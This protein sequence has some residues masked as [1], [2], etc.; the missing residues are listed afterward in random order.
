MNKIIE[1]KPLPD[2][3]LRLKFS[4]GVEGTVDLSD[5]VVDVDPMEC[6]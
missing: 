6:V 5:M 2:Y 3:R 4:D 1:A